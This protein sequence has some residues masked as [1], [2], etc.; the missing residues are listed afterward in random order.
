[1]V[2]IVILLLI[3]VAYTALQLSENPEKAQDMKTEYGEN[4]KGY[5][6]CLSPFIFGK[7][8]INWAK[9]HIGRLP[10]SVD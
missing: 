9:K 8:I 7:A 2:L 3:A 6:L 4:W 10:K 5:A 1:M